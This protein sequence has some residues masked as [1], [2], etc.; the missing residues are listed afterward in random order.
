MT[1]PPATEERRW[2]PC[3]KTAGSTA[4]ALSPVASPPRTTSSSQRRSH[5]PS[6][7][8]TDT[9]SIANLRP[10]G[11]RSP[12]DDWLHALLV[13][14]I[15]SPGSITQDTVDKVAEY[16]KA[17]IPHYWI[18]HLDQT[19][20][21]TIERY[22]LDPASMLYKSVGTLMTEADPAP[23]ITNPLPLTIDWEDLRF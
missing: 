18:V 13:V 1:S 15:V 9:W 8:W 23:T 5:G 21:S 7:S 16:A 14:E 12:A 2:Q 6:R 11:T 4:S 10:L 3:R 19:G 17:G 20:V 22:R